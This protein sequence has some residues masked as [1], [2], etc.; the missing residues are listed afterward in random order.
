MKNSTNNKNTANDSSEYLKKAN[1]RIRPVA[2]LMIKQF[3]DILNIPHGHL[4]E[5]A[6][7]P[8]QVFT[9]VDFL[10]RAKQLIDGITP[11]GTKNPIDSWNT[12]NA[13]I[14]FLKNI[15][16]D[17][18]ISRSCVC[19]SVVHFL[20]LH[21]VNPIY[22][23]FP[24]VPVEHEAFLET[25]IL[26]HCGIV[27]GIIAKPRIFEPDRPITH[28]EMIKIILLTL[29]YN[30]YGQYTPTKVF[31]AHS[32]AD[33]DIVRSLKS[34]MERRGVRG[35]IDEEQIRA[36][37][38]LKRYLADTISDPEML[39][40]AIISSNSIKSNWVTFELEVAFEHQTTSFPK[41]IA[42]QVGNVTMPDFLSH[43]SYVP[44]DFTGNHYIDIAEVERVCEYLIS[45][46]Q[47]IDFKRV[48]PKS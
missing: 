34:Y 20:N 7:K 40:I 2:R 31:F 42:L 21:S 10:V 25:C 45:I 3:E 43:L 22:N 44:V 48:K 39:I 24:D 4:I 28:F 9:F 16:V 5:I 37:I 19:V 1:E 36:G 15:S 33:K 17:S 8:V 30:L 6:D 29:H 26:R 11:I 38:S 46:I 41:I 12:I 14:P 27:H 13:N 32:N 47:D 18:L 23:P 35:W